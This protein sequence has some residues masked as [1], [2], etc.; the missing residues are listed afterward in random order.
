MIWAARALSFFTGFL[1]LSQEILWVRVA[2]FVYRGAP[3]AFGVV[4]GLYLLGIAVGAGLGKRYC[5]SNRNLLRVAGRIL[6][7]A[8]GLDAV[9]PWL[10]AGAFGCGWAVGTLAL[11][12]SV[13]ATS[14]MKSMIFPISHHLGS[15]TSAGKVGSSV[16]KVYFANIV[17]STL[18]PLI[19]GFVLL[20]VLT[21]QQSLMLMAGV[22]LLVGAY[23]LL[24]DGF[25]RGK[26]V[27]AGGAAATVALLMLPGALI[28]MLVTNTG[29]KQGPFKAAIEN[30]YGII[31]LLASNDGDDIVF[32]GNAYDGRVNID[33]LRD[34]NWISR[35]YLLA[36]V[37]PQPKRVLVIGMSAGSWTRV[38]SAFPAIEHM[39]V[40][41]INPGYAQV[42]ERYAEL[43]P[44]L[45]DTRIELHFD[46]G[47]RWL[48][49]HPGASY[50]LIVMNT[51]WHWRA[52]ITM[53]L[54]REFAG[55]LKQHMNPGAVLAYNS[56]HS[57]EVFK[58]A[59]QVF[60][61]VYRYGNFVVAGDQISLP[62]EADAIGRVAALRLDGRPLVDVAQPHV[63]EKLLDCL[64]KF[65]P[66]EVV[67]KEVGHPLDVITDQN[68]VTEYPRGGSIV[69]HFRTRLGL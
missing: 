40:V 67:E 48:K 45:S 54:S 23:C 57:P 50:D 33:F 16:S 59:A 22:T 60:P 38:L 39:D 25:P 19:T 66:Y 46:D 37:K 34:S 14:M 32:G 13:V 28:E 29:D 27:L 18:G 21:L 17:G 12:L 7:V 42:T 9:F 49:R 11:A 51:T 69:G 65:E 20:Q 64:K 58:T 53:L 35:L 62:P 63:L 1:S 55:I 8:A 61:A 3:Q 6:L 56:T 68:M 30:R 5:A 31:H 44:L 15:S 24:V 2:G 41:E 52:Y 36:V 43:R 47:R 4:L 10:T 26:L